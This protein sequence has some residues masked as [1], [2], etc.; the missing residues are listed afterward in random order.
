MKQARANLPLLI[1]ILIAKSILDVLV[2]AAFALGFYYSAFNPSLRGSLDEAGPGWIRG[3]VLDF[4]KRDTRP[5]VQLYIDGRFAESR[6]ADFPHPN[7]VTMGLAPDDRHGFF[8]YTPPL[9][10]GVHEAR[11]YVVYKSGGGERRTLQQLGHSLNFVIEAAPAE[12]Y[13]KGWLDSATAMAIRG[14]VV[15]KASP[16][17]PVEVQLYVDNRFVETRLADTSRPDL[18]PG[19]LESDRVGFT[20]L[21]PTLLSGTHEARVYA[22]RK[23]DTDGSRSLRL[24]GR[25][26]I[27]TV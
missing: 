8:F 13:F 1:R 23:S 7:L 4:S 19:G 24:I 2:V 26:I 17:Q 5:E 6:V 9:D 25:P 16:T 3:W 18:K 11:A 14:W 27:F 12:P 21:T 22:V 20:F 15:N 10:P